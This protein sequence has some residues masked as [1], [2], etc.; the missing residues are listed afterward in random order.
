ML[1][2]HHSFGCLFFYRHT[3]DLYSQQ[4]TA[5]LKYKGDEAG[6]QVVPQ[7]WNR[8][9]EVHLHVKVPLVLT[10]LK[11]GELQSQ[12]WGGEAKS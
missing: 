9:E 10:G 3:N 12:S 6:T 5:I 2:R 1:L 8:L 4:K 7:K 11:L